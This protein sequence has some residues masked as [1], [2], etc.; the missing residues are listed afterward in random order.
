MKLNCL[1]KNTKFVDGI[2]LYLRQFAEENVEIGL[3]ATFPMV[4]NELLKDDVE[5]DAES[6]GYLYVNEFSGMNNDSF[7]TEEEIMKFVGKDLQNVVNDAV[8]AILSTPVDPI[9][10]K[11]GKLAPEKQV[12]WGFAKLFNKDVLAL[13]PKS[14]SSKMKEMETLIGKA[15]Q[16]LL[17]KGTP[18][19]TS[20]IDAL[21]SFFEPES[22]KFYTLDGGANTL[23]TLHNAVKKEVTAYAD[24]VAQGLSDEDAEIF[25]AQWEAYTDS[26]MQAAYDIMLGKGAQNQLLNE[27][28]KQIEIDGVK[29]V[30][31][32]GNVN[33]SVLLEDGDSDMIAEKI[34]QLFKDGVKDKTGRVQKFTE[35]QAEAIG[36]FCKNLYD[37]KVVAVA[38][39]KIAN[40]RTKMQSPANIMADFLKDSGFLNLVKNKQGDL[41]LSQA[42]WVGFKKYLLAQKGL[43][44]GIEGAVAAFRSFVETKE[45]SKG[46]LLFDDPQ[47]VEES[48][49]AFRDALTAKFLPTTATPNNL[50]RIIALKKINQGRSFDKQTSQAINKVAGVDEITQEVLDEIEGLAELASQVKGLIVSNSTSPNMSV[51]AGAFAF[52]ILAQMDRK[53]KELLRKSMIDRSSAQRIAKVYS[54][55][56]T[57]ASSTLLINPKNFSENPITAG[58]TNIANTLTLLSNPS[59]F[60][61]VVGKSPKPYLTAWLSYAEGGA[62][63]RI[64]NETDYENDLPVGERK[65]L[66]EI[67]D[68]RTSPMPV[69]RK[70]AKM[71]SALPIT[72]PNVVMRVLFGAFDAMFNSAV[73]NK[74][75]AMSTYHALINMGYSKKEAIDFLDKNVYNL[76]DAQVAELKA[77]N[78]KILDIAL[79]AGLSPTNANMEQNLRNMK[80]AFAQNAILMAAKNNMTQRQAQE[81]TM[82]LVQ[83]SQDAAQM[84]LGTKKIYS[85]SDS[86]GF[87][88]PMQFIYWIGEKATYLQQSN[89]NTQEKYE[90]QGKLGKAARAQFLASSAQNSIGKFAGGVA[91]FL[92]LAVTW[93]PLGFLTYYTLKGNERDLAESNSIIKDVSLADPADIRKYYAMHQLARDI[94][95]RASLGTLG[96]TAILAAYLFDDEDDEEESALFE[97]ITNLSQTKTGRSI[98]QRFIPLGSAA[99]L[100]VMIDN[101]DKKLDTKAERLFEFLSNVMGKKY[102]YYDSFKAAL[103]NRKEGDEVAIAA[104][105]ITDNFTV[106]INQVEQTYEFVTALRS[107][108]DK[109]A[110]DDVLQNEAKKKELYK[111]AETTLDAIMMNGSLE[112]L[113]RVSEGGPINR[114]AEE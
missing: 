44:K 39:Q 52:E 95:V 89:Y 5:I 103:S 36:R 57:T 55:A 2:K 98:I 75:M 104:K 105:L 49:N 37:K 83:A 58:G 23:R 38:Q 97:A 85:K 31:K 60:R 108:F 91:N 61:L 7:S 56:I 9:E 82:A 54:D 68:S 72:V 113:K 46:Q 16:S 62:N 76:T 96:M 93:T 26:V 81:A 40:E 101:P 19:K 114:L 4:Y 35:P 27:S 13:M 64:V 84:I 32:N 74:N 17:P 42:D 12:V 51:N 59:L 63:T 94:V 25:K 99:V 14:V 10:K 102:D 110:I 77:V 53:V 112:T 66:R 67:L 71:L 22:K 79:Q 30:D 69:Y 29:L 18:V 78:D 111:K 87:D 65:R 8:D 45:D 6:L 33:W 1:I 92:A 41:V 20:F 47:K 88:L 86:K 48:V 70:A 106:N 15:A 43:A 11:I 73:T 21:I 24:L 90:K 100:T 107:A 28:L 34:T 3:P 109:D 50:E 80:F